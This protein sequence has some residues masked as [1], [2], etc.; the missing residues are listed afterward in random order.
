MSFKKNDVK[1]T[2]NTGFRETNVKSHD[3]MKGKNSN[4]MTMIN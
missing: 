3:L 4:V 1:N 2:F